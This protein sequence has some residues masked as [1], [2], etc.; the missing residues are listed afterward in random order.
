[1]N[2]RRF[3]QTTGASTITIVAGCSD[4]SGETKPNGS[5]NG[6][7][8]TTDPS[9]DKKTEAETDGSV[10]EDLE[11]SRTHLDSALTALERTDVVENGELGIATS[12][13]FEKYRNTEDRV[14][15][16]PVK[17]AKRILERVRER[18]TGEQAVTGKM[19]LGIAVYTEQKWKEYTAIVRA[20]TA[21]GVSMS[22]MAEGEEQIRKSLDAAQDAV[23]L[24][25]DVPDYHSKATSTLE[26]IRSIDADPGV[27]AWDAD[28]ERAEQVAIAEIIPDMYPAF[29]G[30]RAY[31]TGAI[32]AGRAAALT[33][34]GKYSKAMHFATSGRANMDSASSQ[35]Q[36]ALDR[37]VPYYSEE[38]NL[39]EC[40]TSFYYGT[41][42]TLVDAIQAYQDGTENEGDDL[43][44]GYRDSLDRISEECGSSVEGGN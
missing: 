23:T 32:Q 19:L 40:Q 36:D 9:T 11:R 35:F 1:M 29:V 16:G 31:V 30:F 8:S 27:D 13:N 38:V 10:T 25:G 15:L 5:G 18:A 3:I 7:D 24:I 37:D 20:F 22:K 2:R 6:T 26:R 33:D 12:D 4:S 14:V 43:L 44:A 28:R 41:M 17:E 39:F 21:F 34:N 42:A